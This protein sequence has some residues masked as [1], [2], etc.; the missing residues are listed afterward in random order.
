[1]ESKK[2]KEISDKLFEFGIRMLIQIQFI[3]LP[4]YFIVGEI[5]SRLKIIGP[6]D[7]L[8]PLYVILFIFLLRTFHKFVD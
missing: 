5:M 2:K 7:R 8:T 6:K 3:L 4:M 1:M